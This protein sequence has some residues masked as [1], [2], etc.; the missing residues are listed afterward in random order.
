MA[1]QTEDAPFE[2][3]QKGYTIFAWAS[4]VGT[5]AILVYLFAVMFINTPTGTDNAK[6][7]ADM[8]ALLEDTVLPTKDASEISV[9]E[10]PATC[11]G[12]HLIEGTSS[13]GVVGPDLSLIGSVAAGRVAAAD[14]SGAST[15]AEE[16]IRES[17]LDPNAYLVPNESGKVYSVAGTSIMPQSTA[18]DAGLVDDKAAMDKL[19]AY[20]ASLK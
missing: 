1:Q 19:I 15:T 8:A 9:V 20:L 2:I 11:A 6:L 7:K 4:L 13:G 14:Y 10:L 18:E 5:A 3:F 16:Y 12:C 17:I